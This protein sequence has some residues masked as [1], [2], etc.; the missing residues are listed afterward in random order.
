[1]VLLESDYFKGRAHIDKFIAR[2]P[3]QNIM[4]QR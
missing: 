1:V 3:D 2:V 4:A